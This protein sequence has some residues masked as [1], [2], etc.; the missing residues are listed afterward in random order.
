M[1]VDLPLTIASRY[2]MLRHRARGGMGDVWEAWDETLGRPV[3]LKLLR[4]DLDGTADHRRRFRAEA[5]AAARLS[6]PG[7]VK[8]FDYG[9]RG[10][11]EYLVMELIDGE[12]MSTVIRRHGRLTVQEAMAVVAQT[13]SVLAAAHALD[14][15]H[16]D[17][18]PANLLLQF[19]GR[20]KVTDFGIAHAAD[21][22]SVTDAGT[23]VGTAAYMSPEQV[24]GGIVS[25]SSDI[26]SLGVVAF[27]CLTGR[28]PFRGT[29]P[30]EV[31][32]AH[33]HG[34]V[35][36]FPTPV[37]SP[38]ERLVRA[39]LEK[40]PNRRPGSARAVADA[41]ARLAGRSTARAGEPST[42]ALARRHAP[43][44]SPAPWEVLQALALGLPRTQSTSVVTPDDD[45]PTQRRHHADPAATPTPVVARDATTPP[46]P[47]PAT[48]RPNRILH[49]RAPGAERDP[50][51]ARRPARWRRS[52]SR[53]RRLDEKEARRP[54]GAAMAATSA[55]AL[56]LAS[57]VP[58]AGT[59]PRSP[60]RSSP[61]GR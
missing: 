16:R 15:V 22:P 2:R 29:S 57:L 33:V 24:R 41:A 4:N 32:R 37:P 49:P 43:A 30:I 20:V 53:R 55:V 61:G 44:G 48:R 12:S 39:M 11:I 35:P 8:V 27:Q 21:R 47:V 18:K 58:I 1:T 14:V 19:D 34:P 31:A 13:A 45:W 46:E 9:E 17:I 42:S 25:A 60:S 56:V 10:G 6:H 3:A 40:D 23:V 50:A 7:A 52:A 38:V 28:V 54:A 36:P 5:Q 26:Y 51:T 59:E